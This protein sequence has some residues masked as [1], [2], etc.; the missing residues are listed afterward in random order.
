MGR[1]ARLAG[2]LGWEKDRSCCQVVSDIGPQSSNMGT[3]F[4]PKYILD[5]YPRPYAINAKPY[6]LY[7]LH[8]YGPV[9]KA[10]HRSVDEE[11]AGNAGRSG[12]HRTLRRS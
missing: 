1:T 5:T 8:S 9:R 12:V 4:D 11:F 2:N 10:G 6:S 7:I 3:P